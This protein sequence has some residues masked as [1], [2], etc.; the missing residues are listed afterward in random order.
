VRASTNPMCPQNRITDGRHYIESFAG[1]TQNNFSGDIATVFS[2]IAQVGASGCGLEHQLAAVR[3]AFGDPAMNL[4]A[5]P[6]NQGFLRDNAF[7]AI[8]WITNEDDCSVPPNS[9]LFAP[10]FDML[11]LGFRC[12]EYGIRCGGQRPPTS[13]AGPLL[14]CVSDDAAFE[15]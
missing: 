10:T 5:P 2:C 7:L 3:A 1:G 14:N 13:P 9:Q 8:I 6:G 4:P 15:T 11:P 12:T